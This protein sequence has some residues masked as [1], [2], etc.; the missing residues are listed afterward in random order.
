[1]N[2]ILLGYPGA[3]KGTEAENLKKQGYFHVSTGDLIRAEIKKESPLGKQ[4]KEITSKGNLV[5]DALVTEILLTAIKG[6]DN[7]LFDGFP[8]TLAQAQTLTKYLEDAGQKVKV[9]LLKATEEVVLK[10]LTSRRLCKDCGHIENIYSP[11]YT[12]K[13]TKC[14]GELYTRAD[15]TLESATH[16]LNV[17]KKETEPLLEYYSKQAGYIT[18]D[19]SRT[20]EEV[21]STVKRA[22]EL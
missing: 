5:P 16:R 9:I 1:M 7:V 22:L 18:I 12:G 13:C 10:R 11:S 17:F 4:V 2:I 3:G 14:G 19:A 20:I 21:A 6:K 8:R 15:D